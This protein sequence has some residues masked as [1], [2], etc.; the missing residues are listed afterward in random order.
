ME[1]A[2]SVTEYGLTPF[3]RLFPSQGVAESRVMTLHGHPVV[4][5]D[6]YALMEWYCDDPKCDCRRVMLR[7]FGRWQEATVASI[8]FGFDRDHELA[9]PFLDPLNPQSEYAAALL[10]LVE[11]VLEDPAYVRRLKA[12]Y[13]Q[14]KS[15]VKRASAA[16]TFRASQAPSGPSRGPRAQPGRPRG[17]SRKRKRR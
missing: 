10:E 5:D 11:G 9:G 6:E 12:H 8:S 13:A 15:R 2:S 4:P 14:V 16:P 17:A 1:E 3:V 7:V